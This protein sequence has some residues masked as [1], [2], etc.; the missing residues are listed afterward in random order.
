MGFWVSLSTSPQRVPGRQHDRNHNHLA[1][2]RH[3][4]FSKDDPWQIR[5]KTHPFLW[6]AAQGRAP[7][8]SG[9]VTNPKRTVRYAYI[10]VHTHTHIV[11]TIVAYQK[12]AGSTVDIAFPLLEA[13]DSLRTYIE[14]YMRRRGKKIAS[15]S[16]H[17]VY[18]C[19]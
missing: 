10:A 16:N 15:I 14:L 19:Y 4:S 5:V 18:P 1:L 2:S 7:L 6:Q 12:H 8:R 9:A 11:D 13:F 17:L 3:K